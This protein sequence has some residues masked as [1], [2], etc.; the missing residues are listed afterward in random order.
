M[1]TDSIH[2]CTPVPLGYLLKL[3]FSVRFCLAKYSIGDVIPS[4]PIFSVVSL[5]QFHK[6]GLPFQYEKI[7]RC[8]FTEEP[9]VESS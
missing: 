7:C 5:S 9:S 4:F 6:Q 2:K 3:S 1:P 8:R